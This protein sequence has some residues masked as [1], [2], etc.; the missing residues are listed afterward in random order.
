MSLMTDRNKIRAQSLQAAINAAQRIQ[1]KPE[2]APPMPKPVALPRPEYQDVYM[3]R[4]RLSR[5]RMLL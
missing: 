5:W 1:L 3:P 4:S 2:L